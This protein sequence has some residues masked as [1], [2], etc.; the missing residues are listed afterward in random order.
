MGALAAG[1]MLNHDY[2]AAK[3]L[4]AS[5]WQITLLTMIWPIIKPKIL[6]CQSNQT[7]FIITVRPESSI[8]Y[9]L[10]PLSICIKPFEPVAM[11]NLKNILM[12]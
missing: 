12:M 10:K 6:I 7:D 2:I 4:H 3:G 5:V 1:V 9:L 11:I 8:I